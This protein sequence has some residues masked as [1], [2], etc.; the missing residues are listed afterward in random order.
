[1]RE[2]AAGWSI[3]EWTPE[4]E[5]WTELLA[6]IEAEG[7][8]DWV[9]FRADFHRSSH[10]LVAGAG[11]AIAGFLRLAI[12]PIGPDMGCPPL[13]LAGAELTEAKV[14]AFGVPAAW[15]RRGAGRALQEAAISFARAR[16]C[17]QL[18]SHSDGAHQ[19]NQQ[20]K[21][22]MGFAVHPI[23]RGDDERGAYFVMPLRGA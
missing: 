9:A 14:L 5:R 3:E 6:L 10:L 18:R 16:G 15:R 8:A 23:V 17:H 13:T 1:M 11:A 20:L 21:L 22:A 2:P 4:H 12:Q 19:A 7:Q